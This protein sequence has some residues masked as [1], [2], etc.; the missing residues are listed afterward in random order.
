MDL[1]QETTRTSLWD[2]CACLYGFAAQ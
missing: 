1:P 2:N